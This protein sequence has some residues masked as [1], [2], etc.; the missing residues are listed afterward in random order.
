[1]KYFGLL[2]TA[3]ISLTSFTPSYAQKAPLE[4]Q[5]SNEPVKE[6]YVQ[7][8]FF[9]EKG[10]SIATN[11][12]VKNCY[13]VNSRFEVRLEKDLFSSDIIATSLK[14]GQRI[15]IENPEKYTKLK[16][17]ELLKRMFS[18]QKKSI[19]K[20]SK[21]VLNAI[22]HCHIIKT[23]T[24]DEVILARGYPPAHITPSLDMDT[25]QYWHRRLAYGQ[26]IF[27]NNK[28]SDIVKNVQAKEYSTP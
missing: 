6:M 23:M 8:G 19:G 26:V 28:V 20:H 11:Y 10:K 16:T 9:E 13:P 2:A 1:M 18:E 3:I 21:D 25:W 14:T 5:H 17:D 12:G 22:Q 24:K 15:V 7:H 4:P 27:K